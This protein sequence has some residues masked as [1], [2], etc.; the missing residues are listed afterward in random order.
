LAGNKGLGIGA[1]YAVTFPQTAGFLNSLLNL[2]A[3][4]DF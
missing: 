2:E 3:G 1:S 4:L